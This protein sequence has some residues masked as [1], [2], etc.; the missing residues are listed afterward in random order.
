M[1]KK[2][3]FII[4]ISNS[5][6]SISKLLIGE[7]LTIYIEP[8]SLGKSIKSGDIL[9]IDVDKRKMFTEIIKVYGEGKSLLVRMVEKPYGLNQSSMKTLT[10]Q[11]I[12]WFKRRPRILRDLAALL[13]HDYDHRSPKDFETQHIAYRDAVKSRDLI[14][15]NSL[16]RAN[17]RLKKDLTMLW[18]F[19]AAYRALYDLQSLSK[20]IGDPEDGVQVIKTESKSPL[21]IEILASF[22]YYAAIVTASAIFAAYKNIKDGI[23]F[24]N[25]L[26][27]FCRN[28][29]DVSVK[30]PRL[31]ESIA[32]RLTTTDKDL[33]ILLLA[34]HLMMYRIASKPPHEVEAIVR[35]YLKVGKV[36]FANSPEMLTIDIDL[37]K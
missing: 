32:R 19:S 16:K 24:Y 7:E 14:K 13:S 25:D 9:L 21:F 8:D 28:S 29:K 26:V 12:D 4:R 37:I 33:K 17:I 3:N 18:Q 20:L 27:A 22:N 6:K 34:S 31:V 10:V 23:D 30:F 11:R 36:I 15:A 2:Q 1:V 35:K 5:Q